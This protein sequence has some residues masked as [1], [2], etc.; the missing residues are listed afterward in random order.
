[1]VDKNNKNPLEELYT[2]SGQ[3]DQEALL[4]T[5]KPYIRL[6]RETGTVIFTPIGMGLSATKKILLLFLAKKALYLLGA[7]SSEYLAPKD[8]KLEFGKNIPH[9]TIDASL[10]RFLERGP[11]KVQNGKYFIPDFNFYQVQEIFNQS[12]NK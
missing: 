3:V 6:Y 4:S 7:V 10:K 1:M 9:G 12:N 8:V 2:D 11:L 5:L